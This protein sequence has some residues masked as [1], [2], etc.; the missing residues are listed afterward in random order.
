MKLAYKAGAGDAQMGVSM[1]GV[2]ARSQLVA[3]GKV[4]AQSNDSQSKDSNFAHACAW[5]YA[6]GGTV[7]IQ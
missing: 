5:T 7:G 3:C 1:H 2:I 6:S 4:F